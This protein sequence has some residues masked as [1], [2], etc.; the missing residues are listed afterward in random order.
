MA[1]LTRNQ[2]RTTV[3][4]YFLQE[5]WLPAGTTNKNWDEVTMDQIDFDDPPL[6]ADPDFQKRKA[7]MDL[8][9]VFRSVGAHMPNA[10]EIL[11]DEEQTLGDL[12]KWY[13]DN[14]E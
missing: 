3:F 8:Q 10:L 2:C 11:K 7:S 6:P 14:Q 12:A 13:F 1:K 9:V 5:G 4:I